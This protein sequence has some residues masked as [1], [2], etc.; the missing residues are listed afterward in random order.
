MF[1]CCKH[2]TDL[3]RGASLFSLRAADV[4]VLHV[5]HEE[6]ADRRDERVPS[7]DSRVGAARDLQ[8]GRLTGPKMT[9]TTR[10]RPAEVRA[11]R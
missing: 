8:A 5:D 2:W 7:G 11:S 6:L 4:K 1:R 10:L 9:C 3:E